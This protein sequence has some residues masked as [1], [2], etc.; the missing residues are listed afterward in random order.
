MTNEDLNDAVDDDNADDA[1]IK[2]KITICFR[3]IQSL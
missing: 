3:T 1:V 2:Y